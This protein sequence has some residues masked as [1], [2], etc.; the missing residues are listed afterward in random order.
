MKYEKKILGLVQKEWCYRKIFSKF[1][2]QRRW[3][4]EAE[5]LGLLCERP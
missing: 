4:L 3:K 2:E 5:P 1:W